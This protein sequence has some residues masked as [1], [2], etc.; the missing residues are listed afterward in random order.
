MNGFP[1]SPQHDDL[2]V[3]SV[4]RQGGT[5]AIVISKN[6]EF[7]AAGVLNHWKAGR[8]R[9]YFKMIMCRHCGRSILKEYK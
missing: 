2:M 4:S 1:G 8:K 5:N 9:P 3:D 6:D 7:V